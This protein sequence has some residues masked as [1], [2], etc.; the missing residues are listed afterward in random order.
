VSGV[1]HGPL[2]DSEAPMTVIERWLALELAVVAL[3]RGDGVT[4]A[5]IG[6]L[7]DALVG[8]ATLDRR[9]AAAYDAMLYA[10]GAMRTWRMS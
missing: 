3:T 6:E 5:V 9:G 10:T 1:L 7:V 8:A 2:V 4:L